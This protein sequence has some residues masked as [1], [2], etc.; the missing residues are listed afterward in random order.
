M[1]KEQEVLELLQDKMNECDELIAEI[2]Q[3]RYN[4]E[5]IVIAIKGKFQFPEKNDTAC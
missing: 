5:D 4:I 3:L 2:A 1:V